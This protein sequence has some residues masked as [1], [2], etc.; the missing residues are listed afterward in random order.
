MD[1]CTQKRKTAVNAAVEIQACRQC[2]KK[3]GFSYRPENVC[4]WL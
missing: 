3:T 1:V 4:R 2:V